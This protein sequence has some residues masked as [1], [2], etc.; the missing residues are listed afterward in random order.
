MIALECLSIHSKSF[1]ILKMYYFSMVSG[2][3]FAIGMLMIVLGFMIFSI[4]I[5]PQWLWSIGLRD[6]AMTNFLSKQMGVWFIPISLAIIIG[7]IVVMGK[8][9]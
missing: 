6:V 7:G 2:R 3:G 4:F 8:V 9:Q 1:I 5:S